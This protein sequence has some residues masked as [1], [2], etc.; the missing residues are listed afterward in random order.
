[1]IG[2]EKDEAGGIIPPPKNIDVEWKKY[3][4][5]MNDM[6]DDAEIE[7]EI[8]AEQKIRS[9]N[10]KLVTISII[11]LALPMLIFIKVQQ[12]SSI[13]QPLVNKEPLVE[14]VAFPAQK[15]SSSVSQTNHSTSKILAPL[16]KLTKVSA[17]STKTALLTS[18]ILIPEKYDSRKVFKTKS[19]EQDISSPVNEHFVQLGAFLFKKN[20]GNL[21]KKVESEGFKTV[22]SVH[23]VQSTQYQVYI[24]NFNEINNIESKQVELV[25]SGFT[26]SIK[27]IDNTYTLKLGTFSDE[28]GSNILIDKLRNHGFSPSLKKNLVKKKTYIVRVEG[29]A[30]KDAAQKMRQALANHGF[31]NSFIQ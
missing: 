8:E 27:K 7:A 22:I 30:T 15:S 28:Y 4:K 17:D 14:K 2:I 3:N 13:I 9:K 31:K 21:S 29:L 19:V 6:F 18:K 12:E 10:S 1:M 11:S 23:D 25:A 24:G 20:A 5:R 26:A 16:E